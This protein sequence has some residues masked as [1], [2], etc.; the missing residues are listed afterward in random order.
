MTNSSNTWAA[1]KSSGSAGAL[2]SHL[3]IALQS[4]TILVALSDVNCTYN[5]YYCACC[6]ARKLFR[7]ATRFLVTTSPFSDPSELQDWATMSEMVGSLFIWGYQATVDYYGWAPFD[8][9]TPAGLEAFKNT[10]SEAKRVSEVVV[11]NRL[12]SRKSTFGSWVLSQNAGGAG[13]L[14][15]FTKPRMAWSPHGA[16]EVG[17]KGAPPTLQNAVDTEAKRWEELWKSVGP[18]ESLDWTSQAPLRR[19]TP[20][21]IRAAANAFSAQTGVGGTTCTQGGLQCFRTFRCG[22]LVFSFFPWRNWV[23]CRRSFG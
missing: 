6:A 8:L 14:H 15:K 18:F 13:A 11:K 19:L 7:C 16:F 23:W 22:V 1:A 20:G 5:K 9:G 17:A 10:I 12:E 4:N 21:E 2:R 3:R